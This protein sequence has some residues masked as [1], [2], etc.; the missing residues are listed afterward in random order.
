MSLPNKT[1]SY[2][3]PKS[4]GV[5]VAVVWDEGY[6]SYRGRS[7][8]RTGRFFGSTAN[9]CREKS[10]EVVVDKIVRIIRIVR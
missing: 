5:N 2:N 3:Y 4:G 7:H 6:Y 10:A 1:K 8:G 9:N